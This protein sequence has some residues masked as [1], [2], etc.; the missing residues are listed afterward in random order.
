MRSKSGSFCSASALAVVAREAEDAAPPALDDDE[1][2]LE[3]PLAARERK[4]TAIAGAP[5]RLRVVA[6]DE[7]E[8]VEALGHL[9]ELPVGVAGERLAVA[10]RVAR[11]HQVGGEGLARLRGRG[12]GDDGLV[13][14]VAGDVE[15][16]V[17]LLVAR[18]Q[19][20]AFCTNTPEAA[21]QGRS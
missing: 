5:P 2:L 9:G 17:S 13:V 15:G 10:Q 16:D 4:R 14:P 21:S 11:H 20:T 1:P 19:S 8:A 3:R 6:S 18:H 12:V 7:L